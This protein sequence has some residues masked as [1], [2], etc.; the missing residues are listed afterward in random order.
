ML[1][2]PYVLM[3]FVEG[4]GEIIIEYVLSYFLHRSDLEKN[5]NRLYIVP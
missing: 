2:H 5:E 4:F 1:L 3:R